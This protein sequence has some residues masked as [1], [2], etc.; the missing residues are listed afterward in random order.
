MTTNWNSKNQ[1][2]KNQQCMAYTNTH[3][4]TN[5]CKSQRLKT[6]AHTNSNTHR[7]SQIADDAENKQ[8]FQLILAVRMLFI[9]FYRR[10]GIQS[11]M[12]RIAG[13]IQISQYTL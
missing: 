7:K 4:H 12:D 8:I 9:A 11:K 3:T 13:S 2:Q 10:G 6:H 5:V 1:Q